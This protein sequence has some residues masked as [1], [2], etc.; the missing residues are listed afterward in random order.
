M[1][2]IVVHCT[3]VVSCSAILVCLEVYFY[4]IDLINLLIKIKEVLIESI[5]ISKYCGRKALN[6]VERLGS[7]EDRGDGYDIFLIKF[8][9]LIYVNF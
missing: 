3:T 7:W 1:F 6:P 8:I 2:E 5:L 4:V 9:M